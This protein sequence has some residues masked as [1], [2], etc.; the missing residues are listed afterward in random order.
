MKNRLSSQCALLSLRDKQIAVPKFLC[1]KFPCPIRNFAPPSRLSTKLPT[2]EKSPADS[3]RPQI[4]NLIC[5]RL[6]S[7]GIPPRFRFAFLC[8][9]RASVVQSL[10]LSDHRDAMN[11]ENQRQGTA[12]SAPRKSERADFLQRAH[13]RP[14]GPPEPSPGL[15]AAMPWV[16]GCRETQ[17][18]EGAREPATIRRLT[19]PERHSTCLAVHSRFK[20]FGRCSHRTRFDCA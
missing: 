15:S 1:P 5:G 6:E 17:R 13:P 20:L 4:G 12:S 10:G 14:N 7:A 18:P 9:H 11:T 3:S 8:V 16:N 19:I 2:A